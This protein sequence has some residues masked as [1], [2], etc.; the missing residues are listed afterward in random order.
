MPIYLWDIK[1]A[2][3]ETN[4]QLICDKAEGSDDLLTA[5]F[6]RGW[7]SVFFK[8]NTQLGWVV[9]KAG[10]AFDKCGIDI[11]FNGETVW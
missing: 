3:D 2:T 9:H 7:T 1:I 11:E 4:A 8:P 5:Y 10:H 6:Q